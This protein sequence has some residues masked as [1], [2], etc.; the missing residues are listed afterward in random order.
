MMIYKAD[1]LNNDWPQ[2]CLY[3]DGRDTWVLSRPLSGPFLW[4]VKA[5]WEVLRGRAD[6]IKWTGQP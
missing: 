5:A 2:T 6:A 3:I 4:R 1:D